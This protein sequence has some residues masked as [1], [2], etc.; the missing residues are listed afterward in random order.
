MNNSGYDQNRPLAEQV[1]ERLKEYILEKK[2]KSGDKLPTETMLSK[3]MMLR[4]AQ[5]GKQS[6]GWNLRI[7]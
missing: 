3:E 4:G 7:F 2:L 5:F 1:A 6:N